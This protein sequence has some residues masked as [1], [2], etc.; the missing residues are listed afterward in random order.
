[1]LNAGTAAHDVATRCGHMDA[2]RCLSQITMQT[3]IVSGRVGNN[4]N[5]KFV[6][7]KVN[8]NSARGL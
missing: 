7:L 4:M 3:H 2:T 8:I 5:T 6:V 1:M